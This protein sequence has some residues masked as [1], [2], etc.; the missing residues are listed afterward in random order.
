[1]NML[2]TGNFA[3]VTFVV[4]GNTKIRAHKCIIANRCKVFLNMFAHGMK[5]QVD[6]V[7]TVQDISVPTFK[8]LL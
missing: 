1:M 6:S 4:G 2:E 8:N 5:E 3:D 7:V